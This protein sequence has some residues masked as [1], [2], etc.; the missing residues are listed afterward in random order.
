MSASDL[1]PKLDTGCDTPL[2]TGAR[3]QIEA[4]ETLVKV[5]PA[6]G[7]LVSSWWTCTRCGYQ[8]NGGPPPHCMFNAEPA[9]CPL[10]KDPV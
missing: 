9:D 3:Q 5:L 10:G 4:A 1:R 8:Q 7:P 6:G 2:E